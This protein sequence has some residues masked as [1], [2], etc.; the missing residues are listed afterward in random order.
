MSN[1]LYFFNHLKESVL[2]SSKVQKLLFPE[3][4]KEWK[5]NDF[6]VLSQTIGKTLEEA[7]HISPSLKLNTGTTISVSTLER[8][9][10]HG[11]ELGTPIELR[12]IK[13]LN[14]LCWFIEYK[15]WEDFIEKNHSDLDE[16]KIALPF[17]IKDFMFEALSA[18]FQ[19]YKD[20]P[21]IDTKNLLKYFH[22]GGPGY[23]RIFH[24][25]N[26]SLSKNWSINSNHN[27]SD[28]DILN[29]KIL[30]SSETM[31][32]LE[33]REYWYLR[34]HSRREPNVEKLIYDKLNKQYYRIEKK[35]GQWKISINFYANQ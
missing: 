7:N 24:I 32:E 25:L 13:T 34:W 12:K 28:F 30:T 21:N 29:I 17:K 19:A 20:L 4:L 18:E 2:E 35:E 31:I 15:S 33:T 23:K 1:L 11:Y 8:I 16:K 6:V 26:L 27:P 22:E 9:F 14:K 3:N 5:Q 10:K